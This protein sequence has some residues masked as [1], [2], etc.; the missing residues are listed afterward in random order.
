MSRRAIFDLVRSERD[1]KAWDAGD[2]ALLDK[3][4]D[5][6]GVPRDPEAPAAATSL[7]NDAAFFAQLRRESPFKGGFA[8]PQ[9][10]G[11]KALLAACGAAGWGV[12]WTAYGMGTACWETNRTMQPVREA[13]WKD[14]DWRKRNLRYF[15]HYG[16]GYVQLTWARNYERA[17]RELGLDGKLVVDLDLA[18]DPA[19]AARILVKGMA[20]GWFTSRKLADTLPAAGPA[21][22]AQFKAS[23]PIINGHDKD[24][25]IAAIAMELQA[26]LQAGGWS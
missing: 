3:A 9:V 2:I 22:L 26:A 5:Q 19:I 14:E 18:M 16:R 24:D 12:A 20:E 11:I 8:Q 6:L 15:P 13:Y 7:K 23:R 17:D 10:D 1:G 25:E 21:T 4:L